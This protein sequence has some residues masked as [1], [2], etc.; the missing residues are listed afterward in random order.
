MFPPISRCCRLG[1]HRALALLFYTLCQLAVAAPLSIVLVPGD[2]ATP[3]A[4]SAIKQLRQDSAL[5]DVRFHILPTTTMGEKQLAVLA[6]S[7]AALV[8]NMGRDLANAIAPAVRQ[9]N[10]R[11]G[12][13]FAVGSPFEEGERRAGLTRDEELRA[14]TQAGGADNLAAMV[15]RLLVRDF[16]FSLTVAA[17]RPY[18]NSALWNPRNG[19][20]YERFDDYAAD[21]LAARPDAAGRVWIGVLF[22]RVTAQSGSSPL[23]TSIMDALEA[24]GFNVVPAFG[25]PS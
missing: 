25:Y 22:N 21:Y 3:A 23:L 5:N 8:H 16:G 1:R 19:K 2:P 4:L 12:K 7:D 13:A 10:E 9:M 18:P 20:S 14:Y 6:G 17:P 24:R 15:K 11:G